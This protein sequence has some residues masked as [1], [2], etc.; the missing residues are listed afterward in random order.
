MARIA[1]RCLPASPPRWHQGSA[2]SLEAAQPSAV[3]VCALHASALDGTGTGNPCIDI[4]ALS[5]TMVVLPTTPQPSPQNRFAHSALDFGRSEM[6]YLTSRLRL[7]LCS[8]QMPAS[9]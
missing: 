8:T 4:I 5:R 1:P 9:F 6:T 3:A 7:S 2:V